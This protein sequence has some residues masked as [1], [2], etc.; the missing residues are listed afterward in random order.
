MKRYL[1]LLILAASFCLVQPLVA[2]EQFNQGMNL[3][4]QN[5]GQGAS[6][7]QGFNP[8]E[9]IPGYTNSPPESGYYGGVTSPG[10]DMTAPGSAALNTSEAGK[11]I[12]ES[13]LNTPPDNKPSLDAPFISEGLAMKDKAEAITGG[14]FDGCV[15]Q[16]AG[17]TEI[18]THQCLR[19][20]KIEQYCTRTATIS[21]YYEDTTEIKQIVI[22]SSSIRFTEKNNSFSGEF[23]VSTGGK[24]IAASA[25]Y[26]WNKKLAYGNEHWFMRVTTPFGLIS[27]D[28][29]EGSVT[30]SSGLNITDGQSL[31]FSITN[32]RNKPTVSS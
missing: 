30:L 9:V 8:A 6:A 15:D 4:S 23:K 7:I 14:G 13:I 21:G 26:S 28:D 3:S 1:P 31:P 20:T 27:M 12:T 25:V 17:F 18:T 29:S 11:I 32:R 2:N 16:V 10:V 22:E 24:V 5:K 19:D